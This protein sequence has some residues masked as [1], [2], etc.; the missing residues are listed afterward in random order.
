MASTSEPGQEQG[1]TDTLDRPRHVEHEHRRRGGTGRRRRGEHDQPGDEGPPGAERVGEGAR[2][3][4]RC[5]E[6]EG[7][8]VDGPLQARRGWHRDRR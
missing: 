8:G 4:H 1:G 2:A 7:V 5:P 3:E 6:A